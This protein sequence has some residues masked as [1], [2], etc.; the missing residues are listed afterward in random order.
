MKRILIS[1]VL[2]ATACG[3]LAAFEPPLVLEDRLAPYEPGWE[4]ALSPDWAEPIPPAPAE[5]EITAQAFAALTPAARQ[6]QVA[7]PGALSI[8][9][10]GMAGL[11]I[12]TSPRRGG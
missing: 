11:T 7:C 8:I 2:L 1:L 9:T 4:A 3:C 12:P 6:P 5:P 10:A